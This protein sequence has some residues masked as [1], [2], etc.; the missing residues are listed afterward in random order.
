MQLE[1]AVCREKAR[2]PAAA[3]AVSHRANLDLAPAISRR[4]RRGLLGATDFGISIA[5]EANA[6]NVSPKNSRRDS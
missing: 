2:D 6:P 3:L 4:D 5:A 1:A